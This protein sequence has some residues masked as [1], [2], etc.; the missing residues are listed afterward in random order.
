MSTTPQQPDDG[1]FWESRTGWR[2]LKESLLLEPLVGGSR[3]ASVFGSL[4]LFMFLLQVIT[5]ILLTM[6]YAPSVE[7]AWKSVSFIDRE[8]PFGRFIRALHYWGASAM[9][10]LL[11]VHIIQTFVWGAYKRP[12]ELTWMVGVLLLFCTLGLAFSGYVLPWDEAAYWAT[13]VGLGIA[14]TVPLV[15]AYLRTLLQG[16]PDLGNLTLTRFFTLHAF[17]LPIAV[18]LLAVV[19]L[20][21]FRLHGVTPPWWK[22]PAQLEAAKE[23]FWPGQAW[24]DTVAAMLLMLAL[25]VWCYYWPAPLRAEADPAKPYEARPEWYFMFLFQLLKYFPS[26][27]EVFGTFV[28]PSLFF[29][30]LFFW[31]LLDRNP[32]RNPRHRPVAMSLLTLG[33]TG[34]VSLTVFAITT[35][36]R[37]REPA[38]TVPRPPPVAAG[39]HQKLQV[40]KL[41]SQNCVACH[42][43]D[44]TGGTVRAGMPSI[45]DFASL[46]WQ[47]SHSDTAIEHLI[48]KGKPPLMPAFGEKLSQEQI[49]GLTVFI[50]AF[51]IP[52][53]PAQA[54]AKPAPAVDALP[55]L[56]HDARAA[57]LA[58]SSSEEDARSLLLSTK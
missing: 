26:G 5:G 35:D 7:T 51:G 9:I 50:R 25:A 37:M 52:A 58:V 13:K 24:K 48:Q 54:P 17:V 42:G 21:L 4:L 18:A 10:V 8:V 38:T 33:S 15:G 6:N 53:R 44:G 12:R 11:L 32:A 14:A 34:L 30:L 36:T 28:L 3:W 23:P 40:A 47:A 56:R 55:T 1:G 41:F 57:P 20:Y 45:P 22:S 49:R 39:A 29:L 43:D 31:P 2:R 16:G 19:H 46:P 27:Y